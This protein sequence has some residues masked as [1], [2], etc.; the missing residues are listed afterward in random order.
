LQSGR[1]ARGSQES[2]AAMW[3]FHFVATSLSF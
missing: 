1:D 3:R 2:A